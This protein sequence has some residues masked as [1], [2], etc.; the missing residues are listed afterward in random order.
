MSNTSCTTPHVQYPMYNASCSIPHVQY[1]MS[2][3]PCPIR[4]RKI[5]FDNEKHDIEETNT[6]TFMHNAL[7][8]VS[9]ESIFTFILKYTLYEWMFLCLRILLMNSTNNILIRLVASIAIYP[10][11]P[12]LTFN[13]DELYW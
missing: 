12:I 10:F 3:T 1:P 11:L 4:V 13:P 6:E 9:H 2:N 7:C 5:Y 8:S